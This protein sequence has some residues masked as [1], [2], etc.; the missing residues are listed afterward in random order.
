MSTFALIHGGGYRLLWSSRYVATRMA[1]RLSGQ[2]ASRLE[3]PDGAFES[4][5]WLEKA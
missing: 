1:Q 4:S 5:V 3:L 2:V